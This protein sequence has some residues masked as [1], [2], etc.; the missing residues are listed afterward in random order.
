M[1][2]PSAAIGL[3]DADQHA[4]RARQGR[5]HGAIDLNVRVGA[6]VVSP[7][8]DL[9]KDAG[10]ERAASDQSEELQWTAMVTLFVSR[11]SWAV[12]L[13]IADFVNVLMLARACEAAELVVAKRNFEGHLS[14]EIARD[15][16]GTLKAV[17]EL[18]Q[19]WQKAIDK[20]AERASMAKGPDTRRYLY[21]VGAFLL[22]ACVLK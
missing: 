13:A 15:S 1:Q 9:V 16:E 21:S 12:T 10:E 3:N 17:K 8:G 22:G 18:E 2:E 20:V 19:G 14:P 5:P 7:I 6:S 11:I 4:A